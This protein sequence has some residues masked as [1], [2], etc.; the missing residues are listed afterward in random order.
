MVKKPKSMVKN[1]I[2]CCNKKLLIDP[3]MEKKGKI[4]V[5]K[6]LQVGPKVK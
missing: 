3:K 2:N 4:V 1:P 6:K 5:N